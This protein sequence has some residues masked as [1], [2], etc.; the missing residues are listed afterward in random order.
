ML[1]F[2]ALSSLPF[3]VLL[4][5]L[6]HEPIL[7]AEASKGVTLW[8]LVKRLL[9][10]CELSDTGYCTT[11][12]A[13]LVRPSDRI[14]LTFYSMEDSFRW[15]SG[16]II[17]AA[18]IESWYICSPKRGSSSNDAWMLLSPSRWSCVLTSWWHFP[19]LP[20]HKMSAIAIL[21]SMESIA[22]LIP[23]RKLFFSNR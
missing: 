18:I 1:F 13:L 6:Y 9:L 11:S 15:R 12:V 4:L 8:F 23:A 21:H 10:F 22:T 5:D 2:L 3:F 20:S 7:W 16:E 17:N 14:P 19:W